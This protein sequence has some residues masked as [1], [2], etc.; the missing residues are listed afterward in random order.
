MAEISEVW[1]KITV[2]AGRKKS[3]V[4]LPNGIVM[5][6]SSNHDFTRSH[7]KQMD[8]IKRWF[9]S[10]YDL[11]ALT[12]VKIWCWAR[13]WIRKRFHIVQ[14]KTKGDPKGGE[15]IL[16]R[17]QTHG[18]RAGFDRKHTR[19]AYHRKWGSGIGFRDI[20]VVHCT[21]LATGEPFVA[22]TYHHPPPRT[23]KTRVDD[24]SAAT[25]NEVVK[26]HSDEMVVVFGDFNAHKKDD[27]GNLVRDFGGA[28]LG[29][30]RS[31]DLGWT[32]RPDQVERVGKSVRP[33]RNDKHPEQYWSLRA[34][35]CP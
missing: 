32:N 22:V 19:R 10:G 2:W 23:H 34:L 16:V 1:R 15:V 11:I 30:D 33:N 27:I 3:N 29:D 21:N 20:P 6:V 9:N 35:S 13:P 4:R 7:K 28:W 24:V 14:R 12:E 8:D 25:L 18:G 5:L 17:K 31:I 26:F